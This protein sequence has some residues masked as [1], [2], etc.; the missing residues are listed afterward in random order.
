MLTTK[1]LTKGERLILSRRRSGYTKAE[2]AEWYGVSLYRYTRWEADE[3]DDVPAEQIGRLEPYEACHILRR[4]AGLKVGELAVLADISTWWI[5]QIESGDVPADRLR[6]FW[7]GCRWSS[8]TAARKASRV[9][10]GA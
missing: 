6:A 5:T 1:E 2:A 7:D 8:K 9:R 10:Q 3:G 4:R